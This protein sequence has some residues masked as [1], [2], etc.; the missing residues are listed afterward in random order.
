MGC[1]PVAE[2]FDFVAVAAAEAASILSAAQEA[3]ASYMKSWEKTD[4]LNFGHAPQMTKKKKSF[5]RVVV[6]ARCCSRGRAFG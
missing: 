6:V 3:V 4:S 2:I 1:V 5:G